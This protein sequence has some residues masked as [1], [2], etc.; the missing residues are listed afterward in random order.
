MNEY[1]ARDTAKVE[2]KHP[3]MS[4]IK[5]MP[6]YQENADGS[7]TAPA[8][9]AWGEAMAPYWRAGEAVHR[10][11]TG[12]AFEPRTRYKGKRSMMTYRGRLYRV[13]DGEMVLA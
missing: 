10:S 12:T 8:K 4:D 3:T 2:A 7:W 6:G 9:G 13:V 1:D 11:R 5:A